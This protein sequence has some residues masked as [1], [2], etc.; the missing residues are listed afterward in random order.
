M[1]V[2]GG[3][4]ASETTFILETRIRGDRC[5]KAETTVPF[6]VSGLEI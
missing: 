2:I 4:E 6:R 5:L 1:N 3:Y